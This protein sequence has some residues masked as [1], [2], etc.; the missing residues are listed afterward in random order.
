MKVKPSWIAF[1]LFTARY[2]N[3]LFFTENFTNN[4]GNG[5]DDHNRHG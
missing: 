4:L 1:L 5:Y 3:A 2:L